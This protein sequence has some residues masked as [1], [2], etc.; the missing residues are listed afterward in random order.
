[1]RKAGPC[2]GGQVF[3]PGQTGFSRKAVFTGEGVTVALYCWQTIAG[4]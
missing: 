1:M 2:P 4:R 3:F